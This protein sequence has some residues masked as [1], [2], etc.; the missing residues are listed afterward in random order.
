MRFLKYHISVMLPLFLLFFSVESFYVLKKIIDKYETN[1]H[2]DYSIILVSKV[3]LDESL[4]KKKVSD[5]SSLKIIKTDKIVDRLK[6]NITEGDIKKLKNI[7]P[8]FYSLKLKKLPNTKEL[9]II[10]NKLMDI[11]GVKSVSTF[12]KSYSK[13]YNFLI[14]DKMLLLFFA[15]LVGVIV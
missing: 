10:K 8:L 7:L 13:F 5:I 14:F 11:P 9:L 3:P 12:K 4:L 6:N 15:V 1:L 2:N